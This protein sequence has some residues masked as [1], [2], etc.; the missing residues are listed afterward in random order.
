MKF[1]AP[2]P[3]FVRVEDAK[4][5]KEL[6]DWLIQLGY[7][8][9]DQYWAGYIRVIRCW[10]T[11]KGISIAGEYPC[12]QVSKTDIDCG[13]NIELFKALAVMNDENDWDQWFVCEHIGN[14]NEMVLA[15][16]DDTLA[17]IQSGDGY[18]KATAEEIAEYFKNKEN[19]K[20][21]V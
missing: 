13:S 2:S 9:Y 19:E 6:M 21:C 10:T 7:N 17:Y 5:R 15:D 20:D 3:F 1:T 4:K 8:I 18:R 14:A 12:T 16:S 11:L